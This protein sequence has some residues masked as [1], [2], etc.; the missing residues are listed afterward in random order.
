[1]SHGLHHYRCESFEDS[2]RELGARL[3]PFGITVKQ[4]GESC[5]EIA[6]GDGRRW[7]EIG[8]VCAYEDGARMVVW[9]CKD[10]TDRESVTLLRAAERVLT[11]GCREAGWVLRTTGTGRQYW[12]TTVL[13]PIDDPSGA[14]A[15]AAVS[16]GDETRDDWW[17]P[18][19][20]SFLPGLAGTTP[21]RR[22][23]P[24]AAALAFSRQHGWHMTNTPPT[25]ALDMLV[26]LD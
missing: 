3:E 15:A 6:T 26:D 7:R 21:E 18:L 16:W 8:D 19:G 23:E 9:P 2:A 22:V 4:S 12:A 17:A 25:W 20:L 24:L 11:H 5:I 13:V 1:M 10:A 14:A